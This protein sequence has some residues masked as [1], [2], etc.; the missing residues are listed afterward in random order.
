M[1]VMRTCLLIVLRHGTESYKEERKEREIEIE[2]KKE[3][4][5]KKEGKK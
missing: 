1:R 5:R 2:R 4:N 3:R